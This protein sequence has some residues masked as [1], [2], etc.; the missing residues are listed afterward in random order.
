MAAAKPL[1]Y[2]GDQYSEIDNYI[3]N[4]D[5]GWSFSW[6]NEAEIISLLKNLSFESLP[7]IFEK[8]LKSRIASENFRKDNLLNLF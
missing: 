3:T 4:F 1:L 7:V 8:G 2:I 5:C 6:E